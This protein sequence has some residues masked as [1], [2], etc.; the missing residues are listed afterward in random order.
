M[1]DVSRCDVG[2]GVKRVNIDWDVF[3]TGDCVVGNVSN[4]CNGNS[5]SV[6]NSILEDISMSAT[7][8]RSLF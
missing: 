3:C 5:G 6:G 1:S 8:A 4:V 7:R 2:D